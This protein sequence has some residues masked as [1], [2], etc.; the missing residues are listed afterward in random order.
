M[1]AVAA[2]LLSVVLDALAADEELT[3]TC[4]KREL[5]TRETAMLLNVSSQYLVRICNEA[6]LPYHWAGAHRRLALD[7]VLAYRSRRDKEHDVKFA[8]LA[9]KSAEAGEYDLPIGW[10]PDGVGL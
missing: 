1:P 6:R 5:T 2:E 7:D 9:R 8:E 4:A 3:M 10:P